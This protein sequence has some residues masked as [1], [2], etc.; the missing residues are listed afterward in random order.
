MRNS[1]RG[2]HIA[3]LPGFGLDFGMKDLSRESESAGEEAVFPTP[4]PVKN[5]QEIISIQ[6]L[7]FHQPTRGRVFSTAEWSGI[8]QRAPAQPQSVHM[9][10][11]G[12]VLPE[13]GLQALLS[14]ALLAGT[15]PQALQPPLDCSC[16][17]LHCPSSPLP[18]TTQQPVEG[19]QRTTWQH[20]WGL[21]PLNL[22]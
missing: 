17:F 4:C 7:A 14:G 19:T 9:V 22:G 12:A 11:G 1:A 20:S 10:C 21:P 13:A 8:Q 2:A 18:Q 6:A 15:S 5:K 16:C 3:I